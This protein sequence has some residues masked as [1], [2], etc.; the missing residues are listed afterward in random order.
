MSVV[1]C[2]VKTHFL[3]CFSLTLATHKKRS[4][5]QLNNLHVSTCIILRLIPVLFNKGPVCKSW[6]KHLMV[7]KHFTNNVNVNP[8]FL[9]FQLISHLCHTGCNVRL[10]S[11]KPR[12]D[13]HSGLLWNLLKQ[14]VQFCA[15]GHTL[16]VMLIISKWK[17]QQLFIFF[18]LYRNETRFCKLHCMFTYTLNP[19]ELLH[20]GPLTYFD[21]DSSNI[22]L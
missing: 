7:R 6:S 19:F 10:K 9:M 4:H 11:Q 15:I 13:P 12:A 1:K 14:Y 21:N 18:S 3:H 22:W 8:T 2:I 20:I 17:K 5:G 16:H